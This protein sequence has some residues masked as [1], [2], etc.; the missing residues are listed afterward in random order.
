MTCATLVVLGKRKRKELEQ[1]PLLSKLDAANAAMLTTRERKDCVHRSIRY[2][3]LCHTSNFLFVS[4]H[5]AILSQCCWSS[6]LNTP[7]AKVP[8]EEIDP[9]VVMEKKGRKRRSKVK[10]RVV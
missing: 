5:N 3:V 10:K 1:T 8:G 9:S 6:A 7:R 4:R 2:A